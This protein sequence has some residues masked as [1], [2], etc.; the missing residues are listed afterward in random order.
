M[1]YA[2][3]PLLVLYGS[4]A[5]R[6]TVGHRAGFANAFAEGLGVTEATPRSTAAN[7][8]R[9]LLVELLEIIG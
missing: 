4:S 9:A 2:R 6:A 8:L 7:E 5:L 3:T 1:L